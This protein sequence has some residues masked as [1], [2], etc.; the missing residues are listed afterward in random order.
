MG[1]AADYGGRLGKFNVKEGTIARL[2][3]GYPS[4]SF[5]VDR[6][7]ARELFNDVGVPKKALA[8]LGEELRR[9]GERGLRGKDGPFNF[10]FTSELEEKNVEEKHPRRSG[11]S[12]AKEGKENAEN[13]DRGAPDE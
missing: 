6:N 7:E 9:F 5:V 8:E 11:K 2:L 13:G 3:T 4:H 12:E 1:I 10:Y